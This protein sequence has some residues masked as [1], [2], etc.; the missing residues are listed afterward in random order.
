MF[1][2]SLAILRR[3]AVLVPAARFVRAKLGKIS[4]V[5]YGV[6]ETGCRVCSQCA[7]WGKL[8]IST[9]HRVDGSELLIC[10]TPR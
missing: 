3:V 4:S 8:E 5:A 6:V 2:A 9:I 10:H 1:G 7:G